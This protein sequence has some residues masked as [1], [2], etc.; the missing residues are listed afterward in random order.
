MT[1]TLPRSTAPPVEGPLPPQSLE[2]ERSVLAA[3]MLDFESIGRALELIDPA[4]FYRVGHQKIFEAVV[5][6]YNRNE[7][8]DFITVSE[9]LRKRG[10]LD[11]IGGPS[12]LAQVLE[13]ATTSANLEEHARIVNSKWLLRSLIRSANEIQQ[14]CFA[15]A[16]ESGSILDRA[17]QRIFA[18][19]DKRVRQGLVALKELLKPAFEQIQS[20]YERKTLVTGVPS[21]YDDLDKMTSGFQNGD[22]VIIA[23]RPS[24]GKTSL[25]INIAENAAIHHKIP[26]AVF[27]LEMSK[28]QLVLRMLGSQSEVP[29]HKIRNGFL[30]QEDWPRLTTG[31]GLLTQAPI[32]IDDSASLTVFEIRAKCRRLVAEGKLGLVVVDYLQLIRGSGRPE[33]RVQEV[34]QITRGLKALAKELNVPIIALS[35]LSRAPE[36][37]GNDRRP[38]LSDLRESGSVEQDSDV[39]VFVFREEYYKPDDPTLKGKATL[40]VSK[41]R[42]GPTGDITLTFLRECTKFLP[43]SP[44]T[45]EEGESAF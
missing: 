22:L 15:D 26:I 10:D 13:Y 36:Q 5:A 21:G 44:I 14:E 24:M 18:I 27:S 19:T 43:Y 34:S 2:A 20:L 28:E 4:A 29:L 3:M 16:D 7:K 23:G 35:Q 11:A 42:N 41:Q 17:E 32:M 40:I 38:Q 30:G 1:D 25:A 6:L 8:A 37:R 31:A 39:V 12:A 45:M 33:N 9:E